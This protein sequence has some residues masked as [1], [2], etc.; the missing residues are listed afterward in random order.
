MDPAIVAAPSTPLDSH[1]WSGVS[2]DAT[3]LR[4]A[5]SVDSARWTPGALVGLFVRPTTDATDGDPRWFPIEDNTADTLWVRGDLPSLLIAGL[6]SGAP[7]E[8]YDL[9][10]TLDSSCIDAANGEETSPTDLEGTARYDETSH[11]DVYDCTGIPGCIPY[12]DLGAYE[13]HP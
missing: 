6:E 11:A 8:L 2:Y 3:S 7:Y 4:T 5:L 1:T 9:H 13:Y 10:L 12:A